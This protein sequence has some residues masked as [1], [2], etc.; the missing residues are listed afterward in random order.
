MQSIKLA[1]GLMALSGAL[2]G[3]AVDNARP[4]VG[5]GMA[6]YSDIKRNADGTYVA[7]VEASP[8]RGRIGGAK[9]LVA[10]DASDKCQSMGKSMKVVR[11]ETESHL[12]V[13]GVA[14]LIFSCV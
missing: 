12:L 9:A 10:K 6:Y 11:D 14:R 2:A 7:A 13:N 3:C 5:A 8:L 1:L 4:D